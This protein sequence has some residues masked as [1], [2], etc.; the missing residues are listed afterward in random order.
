MFTLFW[1]D[2]VLS[3]HDHDSHADH[4]NQH[5]P[6]SI[7]HDTYTPFIHSITH[8]VSA[9][10]ALP[11]LIQLSSLDETNAVTTDLFAL[12]ALDWQGGV[13]SDLRL[14]PPLRRLSESRAGVRPEPGA[15]AWE[16]GCLVQTRA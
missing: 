1:E 8:S 11:Q 4:K 2:S 6:V 14:V 7:Y 9:D 5:S 12:Y 15:A 10:G 16:G 13:P 3:L